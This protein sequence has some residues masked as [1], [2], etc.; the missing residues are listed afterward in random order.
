MIAVKC[1][2]PH[3]PRLLMVKVPSAM[4]AVFSVRFAALS[5]SAR[6]CAE[7]AVTDVRPASRITGTMS[8]AGEATAMPMLTRPCS[9][10]W[11]RP[12]GE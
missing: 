6:V 3:M 10:V 12:S 1:S 7:I 11:P 2:T 5:V 4:S 8:P 9:T